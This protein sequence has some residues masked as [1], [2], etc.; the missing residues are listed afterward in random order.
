MREKDLVKRINEKQWF[1]SIPIRENIVTS[2]K[3]P[4]DYLNFLLK[5]IDFPS[6]L[7]GKT[8]LD[9]G[10]WDGF[11]SF[12]A[13]KRGAKRV[14]ALDLHPKNRY[15]FELAH[16]LLNSKVE[17][18]QESVYNLSPE[19]I[20]TFD[21]VLFLGVFYHLRYPL[22]ALDR[23]REVTE[24]FCLLETHVIDHCLVT[25]KGDQ[26]FE[27]VAPGLQQIPLFR[28]YRFDELQKG[29]FSNWFGPN[30]AAVEASL[31][32]AGFEPHFLSR[33]ESRAAFK[34]IK[35]AG[36]P[37]YQLS[38]Y[39]GLHKGTEVLEGDDLSTYFPSE[40]NFDEKELERYPFVKGIY[41][42]NWVSGS[43]S[44]SLG[45]PRRA[46]AIEISGILPE[47]F[48]Y[49]FPHR[50]EIFSNGH[51]VH[52]VEI[53]GAGAFLVPIP[54]PEKFRTQSYIELT[55]RSGKVYIP[56][57]LNAGDD[58]RELSFMLKRIAMIE[59]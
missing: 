57:E 43:M 4:L 54:L 24:G 5:Q 56:K 26:S 17:Y 45:V 30:I 34:A 22:L 6:D 41:G 11:F 3:V 14:L 8:M 15:G 40:A 42:D 51:I 21:I 28:F 55:I 12:E 37:E 25:P 2:G 59:D 1:H 44:I 58:P 32:S 9:I 29:D 20:G 46:K 33:W 7:T 10:A 53:E 50:L 38:T 13:E 19:R 49:D 52:E 36:L 39:E 31:W 47:G 18:V 16:Q 35:K 23:I 48:P 27:T